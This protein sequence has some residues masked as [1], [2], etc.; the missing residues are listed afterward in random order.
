MRG[1]EPVV[2]AHVRDLLFSSRI[3]ETAQRLGYRFRAARSLDDLRAALTDPPRLLMLDLTASDL[4]QD[5]ALREIDA[6][7]RPAPVLGWT[8]HAL[9]KATKPLHDRLDRVVT[10][11]TLTAELP[12]L[13]RELVEAGGSAGQGGSA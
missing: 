2:V 13:L 5:A 12:A 1:S 7:G 6:A 10:R 4:D 11:E 8:T 9:W 3:Q